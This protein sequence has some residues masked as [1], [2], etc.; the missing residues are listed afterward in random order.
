M[1]HNTGPAFKLAKNHPVSPQ[2]TRRMLVTSSA[3]RKVTMWP[4][5]W[6][7]I[8]KLSEQEGHRPVSGREECNSSKGSTTSSALRCASDHHINYGHVI[9]QAG[10]HLRQQQTSYKPA[11][12]NHILG[13]CRTSYTARHQNT[14]YCT[15]R[16]CHAYRGST[17]E[18]SRPGWTGQD[19]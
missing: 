17:S 19:T 1:D 14:S 18:P 3:E 7:G 9:S 4:N 13:Q 5:R 2:A 8:S 6:A 11:S 16:I 10:Y 12:I 15:P